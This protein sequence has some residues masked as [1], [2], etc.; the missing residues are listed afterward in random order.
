MCQHV[1]FLVG[2]YDDRT[3]DQFVCLKGAVVR[4]SVTL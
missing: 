4:F 2:G 1:P 3:T